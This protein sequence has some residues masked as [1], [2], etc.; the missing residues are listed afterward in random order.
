L[1]QGL[2]AQ[3]DWET[4]GVAALW[5]LADNPETERDTLQALYKYYRQ[6]SDT[7]GL[8][9]TLLRLEKT[10]PDDDAVHNNFAQ[11]SL[12]LNVEP[13]KARQTARQLVERNPRNPAYAS[14]YAFALLCNG[15]T[16]GALKTM[17]HLTPEQL[18]TPPIAAYYGLILA[19]SEH[20]QEAQHYLA[21]GDKAVLLPEEKALLSRARQD[22]KQRTEQ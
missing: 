14:T 17:Q 5:L 19:R 8:Y 18:N 2:A 20:R 10:M 13:A 15:D 6:R 1:L 3:W 7:A 22:D 12:L 11:V 9:R 4:Q 21:L 16:A